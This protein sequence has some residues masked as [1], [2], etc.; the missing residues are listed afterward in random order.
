M[1]KKVLLRVVSG[2]KAVSTAAL[3]VLADTPS[4]DLLVKKKGVSRK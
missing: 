3:Q 1:R 2:Y 4:I